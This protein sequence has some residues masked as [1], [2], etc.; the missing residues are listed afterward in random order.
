VALEIEL[1][2][3]IEQMSLNPWSADCYIYP[4]ARSIVSVTL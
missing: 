3:S 4:H 1:I 2:Q